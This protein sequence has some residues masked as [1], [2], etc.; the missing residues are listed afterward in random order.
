MYT[1]R[2]LL[3]NGFGF[4]IA[5]NL[6]KLPLLIL[7]VVSKKDMH[8]YLKCLLKYS[9]LFQ[10]NVQIFFTYLNQTTYYNRLKSETDMTTQNL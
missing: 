5:T 7:S 8:N 1:E 2:K 10:L 9:S 4:H 3:D 6:N